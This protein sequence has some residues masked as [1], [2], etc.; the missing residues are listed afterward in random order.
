[1]KKLNISPP[2]AAVLLAIVLFVFSGFLPTSFGADMNAAAGQA[3]NI[4]RLSV[5][6]GIIAAGQTLVIISGR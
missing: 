5:F 2:V 6:L 1:M 3:V 4:V